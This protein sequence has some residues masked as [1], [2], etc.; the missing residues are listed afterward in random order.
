[1]DEGPR[2]PDVLLVTAIT[3]AVTSMAGIWGVSYVVVIASCFV[4]AAIL[5]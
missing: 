4:A 1:M 5:T 2:W 3:V